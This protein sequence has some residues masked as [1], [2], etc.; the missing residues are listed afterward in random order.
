MAI[1][2]RVKVD[3]VVRPHIIM[4]AKLK[5][6]LSEKDIFVVK[7]WRKLKEDK[8]FLLSFIITVAF[9]TIFLIVK[10]SEDDSSAEKDKMNNVYVETEDGLSKDEASNNTD[11]SISLKGYVGTYSRE[12]NLYE[13]LEL[14]DSCKIESYKIIYNVT[15]DDRIEKYFYSSCVGTIKLWED[16]VTYKEDG[17][18]RYITSN[19][20]Y[21]KFLND[22]IKEIRED[23]ILK[24]D[25]DYSINKLEEDL[26]LD[27]DINLYFYGENVVFLK[28]DNLLLLSGKKVLFNAND[29]YY[30]N[31][32]SLDVRFYKSKSKY[33][34]RFI[35]FDNKENVSCYD[36]T[37]ETETFTDGE[38]YTIYKVSYDVETGNFGRVDKEVTR[39]K[40][41]SC[42]YYEEDMKTLKN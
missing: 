34:F 12:V 15:K 39:T 29:E 6:N 40:L 26:L 31:G 19:N 20:T 3:G 2:N 27:K 8:L 22:S 37:E 9:T 33:T 35:V 28:K 36:Q 11:S 4:A 42:Q 24:Y 18:V 16:G 13:P 7:F 10:F 23:E 41:N 25:V 14:T 5:K 32:G 21:F 17:G 1:K 38:L 30:N